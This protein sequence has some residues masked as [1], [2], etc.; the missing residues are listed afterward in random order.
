MRKYGDADRQRLLALI[1]G[2]A[3]RNLA[4]KKTGMSKCTMQRL[5][6]PSRQ[7]VRKVPVVQ[8]QTPGI[9]F[10]HVPR[11]WCTVCHAWIDVAPCVA[12]VARKGCGV[13]SH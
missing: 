9:Q 4:A 3:S 12:C 10:R 11:Y 2:G 8:P 5:L 1:A 13:I 6:G 7:Y